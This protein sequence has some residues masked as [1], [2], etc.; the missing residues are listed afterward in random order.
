[1]INLAQFLLNT[2]DYAHHS[3]CFKGDHYP[4]YFFSLF[5][6]HLKKKQSINYQARDVNTENFA[7][8]QASLE[9]SFLGEKNL[10]WLKNLSTLDAVTQKKIISYCAQYT[11]PHQLSFF[12]EDS[13][14]FSSSTTL[15]ITL[16]T[17]ID[18]QLYQ[19]LYKFF[20]DTAPDN[21]FFT[22]CAEQKKLDLE[23][24]CLLMRYQTLLGRN[25]SQFI[26][27][28]LDRIISSEKSLFTLTGYFFAK[29]KKNFWLAWHTLE[30][31]YPEEFWIVFWSEQLWQAH[32]FVHQ[33][34]QSPQSAA[35]AKKLVS[36]LPF[37]FTQ[38]D[39]RNYATQELIAAHTFLYSYDY[40][41][42]NGLTSLGL[43]LFFNKFL[44][45]K[46]I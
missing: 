1:M 11:G 7:L 42:K 12:I 25:S 31:E 45:N 18:T 37:S 10:V 33:L 13:L 8:L 28:W 20:Y 2:Q 32:L 39:W 30:T 43:D 41:L 19:Q 6:E 9:M 35:E 5:F 36:R 38:K 29:N 16:P 22:V 24:T 4:L 14:P 15:T 27:Q 40:R 3:W 46:F 17:T 23:S 34:Q 21:N 26:E 44:S